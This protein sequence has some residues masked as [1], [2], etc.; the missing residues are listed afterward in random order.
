MAPINLPDGS[1]VS[2]VILPDGA[3]ASEVR[4]PDG[5]T[6]FSGIADEGFEHNDLSG[7]Y[8]GDLSVF[9]IQTG[10]VS[11]GTYAL[12][13]VSQGTLS[14]IVRG[15]EQPW[16]RDYVRILWDQ[17]NPNEAERGK[18][19][20]G[21]ATSVT[22]FF[23]MD[24]YYFY[25][26]V[27]NNNRYLRRV[28]NG[29]NNNLAEDTSSTVAGDQWITASVEFASNGDISFTYDGVT[30]TANDTTYTEL[31]LGFVEFEDAFFDNV[32]FETI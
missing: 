14:L 28:D 32:R 19:G 31:L 6:V 3:S 16:N 2:E 17:Y 25:S 29:S 20:L 12:E 13:S 26:D 11:E 7:N 15:T 9:Q 30:L 4:A 5:S 1:E 23:N 8:G 10:T 24:G 27:P 18:G 21:V 22:G